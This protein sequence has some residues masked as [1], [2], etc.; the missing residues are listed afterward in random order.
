MI[1]LNEI[2]NNLLDEFGLTDLPLVLSK[3]E[4]LCEEDLKT[5]D[6]MNEVFYER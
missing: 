2:Y 3:L 1:R 5:Y 6:E 4:Q